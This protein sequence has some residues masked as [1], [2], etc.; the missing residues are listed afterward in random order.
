MKPTDAVILAGGL[1]LFLYGMKMMGDGLEAVAGNRMKRILERLTT[2]RF[3][4]VVVGISI[5]AVIQS[6]SATTAMLVGFVNSGL[7]SLNQAVWVI[8]GSNIGTTI[9][10]QLIALDI[11]KIAPLIAFIGV[12]MVVFLKRKNIIHSGTIIAGLGVLFIGMTMM[13]SALSPLRQSEFFINLMTSIQNPILGILVG[14]VFTSIIQSSSASVGILQTLALSGLIE[15]HGAVY[16]MLGMKIGTCI[17]A[18]LASIGGNRNAKR[19]VITHYSFNIAE[20]VLFAILFKTTGLVDFVCN[21]TP[22]NPAAQI[23]N[24]H[25]LCAVVMTVI[26]LPLGKYLTRFA[27]KLLQEKEGEVGDMRLAYISHREAMEHS[28]GYTA[29]VVT[30]LQREIHRMFEFAKSNV[31]LG[32]MSIEEK[33][34][35]YMDEINKNEDIVDYLNKE[36]A[37]F[38]SHTISVEMPQNDAETISAMLRVAGNIERIGDHATNFADSARNLITYGV[39][40]SD[41][42]LGEVR[43]MHKVCSDALDNISQRIYV[44][45]D[46]GEIRGDTSDMLTE[47][48]KAEQL[49][50]DITALFREHQL[51]RM[52]DGTCEAEASIIFSEMLTDFERIGDHMLNIAQAYA[53][54]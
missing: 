51:D 54:R 36:I 15:L 43:E 26:L 2:N 18:A 48:V 6:S 7:M 42:A 28:I 52:K 12:V 14:I 4:G 22:S 27:E 45:G 25:T 9:T 21:L 33:T 5:T 3:L 53:H 35:K 31:V 32:F 11:S 34:A 19:V 47:M 49:I 8:M 46:S 50:D 16:I 37:V 24:M 1:A 13:S 17:T 20:A 23:A 29:I 44:P 40:L 38:I 41:T 39:S 30:Q 10:G